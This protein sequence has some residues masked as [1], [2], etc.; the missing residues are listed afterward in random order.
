MEKNK[1]LD[2][3]KYLTY[4]TFTT[5]FSLPINPDGASANEVHEMITFLEEQIVQGVVSL[6]Y[7][8]IFQVK[9][10]GKDISKWVLDSFSIG[11]DDFLDEESTYLVPI[12]VA[13]IAIINE[14]LEVKEYSAEA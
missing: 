10:D 11:G 8:E 1:S 2:S 3:A 7:D 9:S 5:D 12:P 4:Y 6:S 14:R 13:L